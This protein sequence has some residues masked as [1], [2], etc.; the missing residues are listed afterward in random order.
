MTDEQF[1]DLSAQDDE[2]WYERIK[3]GFG[4]DARMS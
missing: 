1:I 4:L 3:Q 2:G